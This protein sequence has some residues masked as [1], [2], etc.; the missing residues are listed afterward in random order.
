MR[1]TISLDDLTNV[2]IKL[3]TLVHSSKLDLA[4]KMFPPLL[5]FT[6]H[7]D[8]LSYEALAINIKSIIGKKTLENLNIILYLKMKS[9]SRYFLNL[10][11]TDYIRLVHYST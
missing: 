9:L 6:V 10:V 2:L 11:A 1:L 7:I 3:S 4:N 5:L 8:P